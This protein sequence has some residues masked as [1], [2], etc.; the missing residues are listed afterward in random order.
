MFNVPVLH[1]WHILRMSHLSRM[2]IVGPGAHQSAIPSSRR[3]VIDQRIKVKC[4]KI[5]VGHMDIDV[6]QMMIW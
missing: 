3:G 5:G 2:M 4:R 1:Q 6:L